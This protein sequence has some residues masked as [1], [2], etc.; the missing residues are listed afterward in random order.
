MTRG[1]VVSLMGLLDYLSREHAHVIGS[2]EPNDGEREDCRAILYRHIVA[3]APIA[4]LAL[5]LNDEQASRFNKLCHEAVALRPAN[6]DADM[7]AHEV[8][9]FQHM[10]RYVQQT[11]ATLGF[12]AIKEQ[13]GRQRAA[14]GV[15]GARQAAR[16]HLGLYDGAQADPLSAFFVGGD[17]AR[18]QMHGSGGGYG[19][20]AGGGYGHGRSTPR[21]SREEEDALFKRLHK[22]NPLGSGRELHAGLLNACHRSNHLPIGCHS[23]AVSEN[24]HAMRD[25][26]VFNHVGA[27]VQLLLCRDL[28]PRDVLESYKTLVRSSRMHVDTYDPA[29]DPRPMR[30]M[31]SAMAILDKASPTPIRKYLPTCSNTQCLGVCVHVHPAD[32]QGISVG[33]RLLPAEISKEALRRAGVNPDALDMRRPLV[34][35]IDPHEGT[36][37]SDA[38]DVLLEASRIHPHKGLCRIVSKEWL[39]N[40]YLQD[41][42]HLYD[43]LNNFMTYCSAGFKWRTWMRYLQTQLPPAA[44][45]LEAYGVPGPDLEPAHR[46]G[47]PLT[48]GVVPH[49]ETVAVEAATMATR[50][51]PPLTGHL[52]AAVVLLVSTTVAAVTVVTVAGVAAAVVAA[53]E[54]VLEAARAVEET[55]AVMPRRPRRM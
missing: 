7:F 18:R 2:C 17:T 50:A 11:T 36:R 25:C 53:A 3:N 24:E 21:Y 22:Q 37:Y 12:H 26:R 35:V 51:A 14:E 45:M 27:N 44:R 28:A 15:D 1:G 52:L 34:E 43:V 19:Y 5:N 46:L 13:M 23:V 29:Y 16:G 41:V 8:Q 20:Q 10:E 40:A 55:V 54:A 9:A 6:D 39:I 38:L 33:R 32:D 31:A 49:A 4:T 47:D 48:I 42:Q 30:L